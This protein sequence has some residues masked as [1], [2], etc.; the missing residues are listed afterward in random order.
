MEYIIQASST[1]GKWVCTDAKNGIVCVFEDKKFNETQN[2][3]LLDD[4]VKPDANLLATSVREMA[5]W[6]RENHY[7]KVMP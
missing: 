1:P 7:E 4:V 5:D 6:L 3:T 2:F